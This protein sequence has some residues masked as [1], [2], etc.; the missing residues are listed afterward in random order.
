MEPKQANK[1]IK[2]CQ[3]LLC[4]LGPVYLLH[5]S[6]NYDEERCFQK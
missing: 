6:K 4:N 1:D 5:V 3:A 2:A